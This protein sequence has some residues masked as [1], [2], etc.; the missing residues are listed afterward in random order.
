MRLPEIG[1]MRVNPIT[2]QSGTSQLDFNGEEI[3]DKVAQLLLTNY[4]NH[5]VMIKGH[6]GQGD[7]DANKI[8]SQER[9][10]VVKQRLIGVHG[11]QANRLFAFGEGADKPPLK[12]AGENIRSYNLRWARVEFVLIENTAN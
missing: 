10:E 5:R 7:K 4:P 9:A 1:T 12:K 2:F 8:L 3:V 11:I 6:T